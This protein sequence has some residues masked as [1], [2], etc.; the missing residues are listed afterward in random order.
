MKAVLI[1]ASIGIALAT[2]SALAAELPLKAPPPVYGWTGC[3]VDGGVGYGMWKQDH[4]TEL[5]EPPWTAITPTV[6]TGGEG[7]LGRVG[8]GCD[9][10][11]SPRWVI[12]IFGDYDFM[13]LSGSFID[14]WSGLIG[15][16]NESGAW[17]VGGRIG[18]LVTPRLLTYIDGGYTQANFSQINLNTYSSPPLGPLISSGLWYPAQTY[19]GLFLGGGTEYA[20]WDILPIHGWFWRTEYRYARYGG[21]DLTLTSAAGP[22]TF[23]PT[24]CGGAADPI[25]T[26]ACGQH[27]RKDVQTVTTGLVWKFNFGGSSPW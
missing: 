13:N 16:E 10:Q 17:G 14:P 15:N 19:R 7:W 12:G 4:Y 3:Y 27:M 21:A 6:S 22:A 24:D 20:L 25:G 26:A 23:G 1:A 2:G 18:F 8:A 5:N 9:Y 11:V